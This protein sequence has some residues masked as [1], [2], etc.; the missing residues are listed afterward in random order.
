M[1]GTSRNDDD[2][3]RDEK[4]VSSKERKVRISRFGQS[5]CLAA[6][7]IADYMTFIVNQCPKS[8][9]TEDGINKG[10]EQT[11]I[12]LPAAVITQ[13]LLRFI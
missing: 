6:V 2:D 9:S 7:T 5:R 3:Q 8:S 13:H 11:R 1:W 4:L 12:L 10:T